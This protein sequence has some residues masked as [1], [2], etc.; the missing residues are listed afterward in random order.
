ME[1]VQQHEWEPDMFPG[2]NCPHCKT[3]MSYL[4]SGE[5]IYRQVGKMNM[6]EEPACITRYPDTQNRRLVMMANTYVGHDWRII[7]DHD[8]IAHMCLNCDL[9]RLK[10]SPLQRIWIYKKHGECVIEWHDHPTGRITVEPGCEPLN[11]S[12]QG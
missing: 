10:L 1:T 9:Q 8:P 12:L 3:V 2:Y 4:L 7:S 6:K 11:V 5:V